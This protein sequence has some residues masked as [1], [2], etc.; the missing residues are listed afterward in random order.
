[1]RLIQMLFLMIFCITTSSYALTTTDLFLVEKI[2]SNGEVV[3]KSEITSSLSLNNM[4]LKSYP[5]LAFTVNAPAKS[6]SMV[7]IRTYP[8]NDFWSIQGAIINFGLTS[9]R[10]LKFGIKSCNGSE[11]AVINVNK[12][13]SLASNQTYLT[14]DVISESASAYDGFYTLDMP[15]G[16]IDEIVRII[17]IHNNKKDKIIIFASTYDPVETTARHM[18]GNMINKIFGESYSNFESLSSLADSLNGSEL[19]ASAAAAAEKEVL[20]ECKQKFGDSSG[21]SL[22]CKN[23]SDGVLKFYILKRFLNNICAS[24]L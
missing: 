21:T 17:E 15:F 12:L 7:T 6:T 22:A 9:S 2:K 5:L 14:E 24:S 16:S 11:L 20:A 1:M 23:L 19:L 18:V 3:I 10:K 4:L 13:N 8:G